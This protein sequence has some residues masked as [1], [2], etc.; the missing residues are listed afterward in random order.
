MLDRLFNS[1]VFR[2]G[3]M[4]FIISAIAILSMF[5]S[6]FISDM[7]D[8]D[9]LI[10]NEAGSLRKQS[11]KILTNIMLLP[12]LAP[13]MHDIQKDKIIDAIE[14]FDKTINAPLMKTPKGKLNE[15]SLS[16]T[17]NDINTA[18]RDELKPMLA[19]AI[20]TPHL[21]S[22]TELLN[23][24]SA[25][26][27]FVQKLNVLVSLYQQRAENRVSLIRMILG[28]SLLVTILMVTFTMLQISRRIE[29]PLTELTASA[30]QIMA[31]DYTAKTTIQQNDELGLLAETMNKMSRAVSQSYGQLER[32]VKQKTVELRQSNDTLELLYR[33]SQLINEPSETLDLSPITK[34]L[35]KIT[36]K[37]DLDLCLTTINSGQPYEHII[38]KEKDL[39]EKC[40]QKD[41][42]SCLSS[43]VNQ[44]VYQNQTTEMRYPINK[45]DINYGVLVCTI[46]DD[47][48]LESWQHQLFSSITTLIANGLHIRQ[49]NEQTRRITILK[50]RN[51]IARELHDSLAQALSYLKFQV[52]RL[53]KLRDKNAT[54][55]QIDDVVD[56]LKT[57][58]S[59]AYLQLR[60]LLTTFRLKIDVAGLQQ[61]FIEMVDSLNDRANGKMVFTLDYQIEGIPLTPNEEIHLMQIAR[62]ATQNALHHSK[63]DNTLV[64]VF[65]DQDKNI[66]LHIIDN[67]V[68]IPGDPSKLNHY[69]LAIIKER[70]QHLKGMVN[71]ENNA[72]GGA[73][74]KLIF[75]PT[76]LI[77]KAS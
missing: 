29:K 73:M 35:S 5:S 52:T 34:E 43:N 66:H 44:S 1:I 55:E 16:K 12:Q 46:E 28:I 24:N 9:A 64:A 77:E 22:D 10:I 6:M 42:G 33:T 63:A 18:W 67:G 74:V 76:Y 53:Q 40:I 20:H 51:V 19:N 60:E 7:A 45:G 3:S 56:E 50:E 54:E 25:I 14:T 57:G 15:V 23:M 58:L 38:T 41:C 17:L 13:S 71:I 59:S 70:S 32:R 68:G 11:Y 72:D 69:G 37:P 8:H 75:R 27:D 30:R 39:P 31:G 65:A 47:F 4:M 49:Q 62:E 61:T 48:P 26:E 2:I 21:L 36:G